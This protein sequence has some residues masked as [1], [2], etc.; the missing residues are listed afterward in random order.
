MMT[1]IRG[2]CRPAFD[3]ILG[4]TR[5]LLIVCV[6]LWFQNSVQRGL[7]TFNNGV[8]GAVNA[9][10]LLPDGITGAG[11]GFTAELLLVN[12]DGSLSPLGPK[13]RF[14]NS[15]AAAQGYVNGVAVDI[16]NVLPSE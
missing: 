2:Q 7:V 3:D 15:S 16:P 1:A 4:F 10:V 12:S 11:E 9:R 5:L 8:A 13:T 14:R 6:I